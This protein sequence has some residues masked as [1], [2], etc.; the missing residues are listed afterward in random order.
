MTTHPLFSEVTAIRPRGAGSYDADVHPEWTIGGTPNGGYLLAILARAAT[1][2]VAHEHVL[3]ISAHYLT[4]PDPG[5]ITV[6]TEVLRSG[7]TAS[8]V[9]ARIVQGGQGCVES[10][11]TVGTLDADVK[12]YWDGGVPDLAPLDPS[13]AMR[14][15]GNSPSGLTLPIMSQIDLRIDPSSLG[16]GVGEPTGRG[17]LHGWLALLGDED[18]DPISLVYAV[19]SFPP[20]TLD[21]E[22]TGW[23][24]TLEL[25]VYVRALPAPGPL[26]VLQKAVLIDG[27]RVDE[28]CYL[29]DSTGRLVA[30]GTQLAGIRL[31]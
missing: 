6:E 9:R 24:P 1:S 3:A 16:F 30:Q 5:P 31:G 10:L 13:R 23:V 25:S 7:R 29:W 21:I 14:I 4:S 11:V 20:A 18:F 8:Q 17:E 22:I 26:R 19:D 28:V 2:E 27:G 12:P 15:E